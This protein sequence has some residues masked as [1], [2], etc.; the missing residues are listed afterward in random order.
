VGFYFKHSEAELFELLEKHHSK[1]KYYS[2]VEDWMIPLIIKYGSLEWQMKTDRYILESSVQVNQPNS[3]IVHIDRSYAGFMYENS[4]YK[5]FISVEYI[6][7]RL[8][9]DVSAGILINGKLV[10]WGFAHD[11]GALGF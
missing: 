2:S 6:K 9:K 3:G 5:D 1:T 11:D 4:D 8:T 10:A 7:E